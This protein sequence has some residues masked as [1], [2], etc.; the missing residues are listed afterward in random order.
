MKGLCMVTTT[1]GSK[2]HHFTSPR[3]KIETDKQLSNIKMTTGKNNYSSK[4][5]AALLTSPES[6]HALLIKLTFYLLSYEIILKAFI[7]IS[8]HNNNNNNDNN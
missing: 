5:I 1:S 4:W 7:Y 6:L 3:L 2:L 8:T